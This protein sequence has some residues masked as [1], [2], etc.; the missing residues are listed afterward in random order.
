MR[1]KWVENE[2][3]VVVKCKYK[4]K[5]GVI[6]CFG[7]DSPRKFAGASLSIFYIAKANNRW[8]L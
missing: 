6:R 7:G 3:A 2:S 8:L 4:K 1:D 5:G